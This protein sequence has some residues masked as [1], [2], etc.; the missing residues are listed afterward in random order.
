[1]KKLLIEIL[2]GVQNLLV[3]LWVLRHRGIYFLDIMS[4]SCLPFWKSGISTCMDKNTSLK[5]LK[6][7]DFP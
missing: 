7:D 5:W 1:M 2:F 6:G 3:E 4:P